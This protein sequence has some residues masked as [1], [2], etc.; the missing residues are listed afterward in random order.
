L[1]AQELSAEGF[2]PSAG[3]VASILLSLALR[4]LSKDKEPLAGSTNSA[5][6][7]ELARRMDAK[8]PS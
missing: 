4:S 5:V 6:A 1:L 8:Q 2:S 3:Q 7:K